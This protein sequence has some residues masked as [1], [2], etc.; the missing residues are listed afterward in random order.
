MNDKKVSHKH[1][2][3]AHLVGKMVFRQL[4]K[5]IK[6]TAIKLNRKPEDLRMELQMFNE[7]PI[8]RLT[9][10][11]GEID[12]NMTDQVKSLEDFVLLAIKKLLK[13]NKAM[14]DEWKI[15]THETLLILKIGETKPILTCKN[16]ITKEEYDLEI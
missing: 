16:S 2:L 13:L 10:T 7:N 12:I 8:I 1:D 11:T 15:E 6:K 3:G 9:D 5:W 14:A 4:S